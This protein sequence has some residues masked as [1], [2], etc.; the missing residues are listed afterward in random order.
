MSRSDVSWYPTVFPDRCDG[1]RELDAPK[2]VEF[3]PHNVFGIYNGKA[4][5]MNP[6][7]C[8]YGCISCESIC[9]RKAI[10]FPQ[11]TTAIP[12]LKRRDKRLLHKTK[13]R[14]CGKIFWAD[15]NVNLCF[16]CEAKENK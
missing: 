6:Q 2:C 16:D 7:N 9:P 14:I 11:R 12:K 8:V 13:C 5:V 10:V 4:V 1:C 3:C 15:R